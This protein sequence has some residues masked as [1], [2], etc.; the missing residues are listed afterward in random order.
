MS[1]EYVPGSQDRKVEDGA[2]YTVLVEVRGNLSRAAAELGLRRGVLK[3]RVDRS[4]ILVSLLQDL[5]QGIVDK[6]EDNIFL[7]VE[8]GDEPM[9]RFVASTLGKDRGW[10]QGVVGKNGGA[11]EIVIRDFGADDRED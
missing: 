2:I 3:E 6:S 7:A 5:R 1:E 11:I 10:S 9:S 8:R 4:P